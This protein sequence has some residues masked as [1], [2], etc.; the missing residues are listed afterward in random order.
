MTTTTAPTRCQAILDEMANIPVIVPGKLG[1]RRNT[2]GKITGWKL[3]RW[4]KGRNET[5]YIPATLVERV[6]EG[7]KGHRR[8]MD[9]VDEYA[10][11][12]GQAALGNVSD[13]DNSKKKP[14]PQ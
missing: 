3:Q 7:T 14:T 4:H 6:A 11:L 9:L 5:R 10:H 8:F 13:A 1:Q 2:N 12:R